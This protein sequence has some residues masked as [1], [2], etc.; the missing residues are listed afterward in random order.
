MKNGKNIGIVV[1]VVGLLLT[2]C[3][4]PLALNFLAIITGGTGFY[5][6][7]FSSRVGRLTASSYVIG[8]QT[9]CAGLLALI[10]LI[11]GIV[12]L[13]QARGNGSTD[14]STPPQ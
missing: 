10:L 5:G 1:T 12:V 4:C 7:L 2:C 11:L 9:I 14:R 6:Q 13:V 8:A 3:L